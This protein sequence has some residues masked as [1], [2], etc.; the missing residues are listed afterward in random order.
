MENMENSNKNHVHLQS[1]TVKEII[2][3]IL[4]RKSYTLN[5]IKPHVA[6]NIENDKDLLKAQ[7]GYIDFLYDYYPIL[8]IYNRERIASLNHYELRQL[9]D[10]NLSNMLRMSIETMALNISYM[11]IYKEAIQLKK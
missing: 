7:E 9:V 10:P 11:D 6:D 3:G 2:K 5:I 1:I 4:S 8:K